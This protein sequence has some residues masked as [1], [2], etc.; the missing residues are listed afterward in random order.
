MWQKVSLP[1]VSSKEVSAEA[2]YPCSGERE[3]ARGRGIGA[4]ADWSCW[5]GDLAVAE[6]IVKTEDEQQ[7]MNEQ[8]L[9]LPE[10]IQWY[11]RQQQLSHYLASEE[12]A[13]LVVN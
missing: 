8:Q 4:S 6:K 13:L 2:R 3:P 7:H 12:P 5:L 9:T 10:E 11:E 1:G